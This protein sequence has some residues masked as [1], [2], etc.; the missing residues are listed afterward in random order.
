M[1]KNWIGPVPAH[2][3]ICNAPI[4]AEF[5]DARTYSGRWGNFCK[6]CFLKH[7]SG[8]LG[9]GFGQHYVKADQTWEKTE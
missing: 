6:V 1:T 3:N 8:R 7:T 5:Y 2:C 4:T 9:T